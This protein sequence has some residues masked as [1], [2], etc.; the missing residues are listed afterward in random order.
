[1]TRGKTEPIKNERSQNPQSHRRCRLFPDYQLPQEE[2][3]RRRAEKE[4]RVKRY[5]KIFTRIQPELIEK[6]YNWYIAI[7]HE[8]GDYFCDRDEEGAVKK[9]R[10]KYPETMLGIMKLNETGLCGRI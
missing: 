4:I 7:E 1:M 3:A 10:Q 6:Y 2:L 5:R 9:A 8:S